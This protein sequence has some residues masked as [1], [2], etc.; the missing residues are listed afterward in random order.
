M[1]A[2]K[3]ENIILSEPVE[4]SG[5]K[6]AF[7][8]QSDIEIWRAFKQGNEVAFAHIYNQYFTVLYRYGSQFSRDRNFIKDAVQDLFMELLRKRT[9]LSDTN[10]IKYYLFKSLKVTIIS[11]L[12]SEKIDYY[13]QIEGFNFG[14]S[15]SIEEKIINSQLDEEKKEHIARALAGLKKK[16]REIIYY[17]FFEEMD[18]LQIASLMSFS[19]PKSAQNLLYRTL[20]LLKESL[21]VVTL[22]HI[23]RNFIC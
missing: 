16:Q 22:L 19:N 23:Y 5:V 13:E 21:Q 1:L 11:K 18:L 6:V 12:K 3:S 4:K 10:S 17:Y 20:H 8:N 7:T 15:L 2:T 14:M 9:R